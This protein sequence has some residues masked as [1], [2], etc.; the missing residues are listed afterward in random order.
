M[1]SSNSK[2]NSVEPFA[3]KFLDL[4]AASN[5]APIYT[6]SPTEARKV[7][8]GAAKANPF[9][10]PTPN[11]PTEMEE[12]ILPVGPK[13]KIRT[14]IFRPQNNKSSSLPVV[15][16]FHGGGW[17]LGSKETHSRII[18][19]LVNG[20]QCALVFVDYERSPEAQYPVAIEEAYAATQ[21]IAENSK[22]FNVEAAKIAL[23]GDSVGGNMVAAVTLLAK[24]RGGPKIAQQIL[25]YP[26]TD[27]NFNT[28]SYQ[29]FAEGYFLTRKAMQ[30]FWDSY[31]PDEAAR[32]QITA[33][34]LQASLEQLK[35][36][37]PALITC[38]ENDVLR[39][40]AEAYAH[41]LAAAGVPV[42]S[43]RML[44][45]IHDNLILGAITLTP[46][47][48]ASTELAILQ[49]KKSFQ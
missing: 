47:P 42:T 16:Y 6:L 23:V 45:T 26:V 44:G 2:L 48:R 32:K 25:F 31:L 4:L 21:Y 9:N 19:D 43:V 24:E 49:L 30:W 5:G 18:H 1:N 34:P 28:G 35:D 10:G 17:V 41:K 38:N 3:Q 13:G 33:S 29:E 14:W 20:A 39:D 11:Q 27:A 37:P 40:E 12:H 22:L 46:A 7:L 15:M 8:E 36:L